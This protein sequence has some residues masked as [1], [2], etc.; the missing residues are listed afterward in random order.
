VVL[1]P[2]PV[3]EFEAEEMRQ[4]ILP[5]RRHQVERLGRTVDEEAGV[6][7]VPIRDDAGIGAYVSKIALEVTRS[8]TK[9]GRTGNRSH[10]QVAV[11]AARDGD[12]AD[13]ML[14]REF[15]SQRCQSTN[16]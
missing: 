14:W 9:R 4:D 1:L 13:R 15:I 7:V 11:D 10:V 5:S 8:D 3:S 12:P 16:S 6:T 2:A